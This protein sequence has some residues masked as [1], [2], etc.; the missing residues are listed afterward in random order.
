LRIQSSLTTRS[1]RGMTTRMSD[2]IRLKRPSV[3]LFTWAGHE[4]SSGVTKNTHTW[5]SASSRH[6]QRRSAGADYAHRTNT[7]RLVIP[8][9][10]SCMRAEEDE[11]TWFLF[12]TEFSVPLACICKIRGNLPLENSIG[13]I[14]ARR[15]STESIFGVN[16]VWKS[17]LI[18][19]SAGCCQWML[20][21]NT[22]N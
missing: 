17:F 6:I 7:L 11:K 19:G 22:F 15:W 1:F 3:G 14:R 2:P 4:V 18:D 20:L 9:V 16:I 10:F 8:Q 12:R 13:C 5:F 21:I